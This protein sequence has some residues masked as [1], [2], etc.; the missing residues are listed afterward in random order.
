MTTMP[1]ENVLAKFMTAWDLEF[2]R[3]QYY[4]DGGYDSN[5]DYGLPG[6]FMRPVSIYLVSTTLSNNLIVL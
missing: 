6:P 4:N 2:E 1:D 5:N 3:A